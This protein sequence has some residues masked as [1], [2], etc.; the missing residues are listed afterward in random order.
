NCGTSCNYFICQA[1]VREL[2]VEPRSFDV[3]VCLGVVQHTPVPEQTI[4]ALAG[5]VKPGGLLAIDHYARNYP[6]TWSRRATRALL[7]SLPPE[8]ARHVALG[9]TRA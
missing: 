3:V 5:Y 4:A 9:I 1:D 6:A 7:L 8:Q 2:P